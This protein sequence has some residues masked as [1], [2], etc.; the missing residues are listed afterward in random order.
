[1]RNLPLTF[2]I[3]SSLVV[4]CPRSG[5]AQSA[6]AAV[7]IAEISADLGT[8]RKPLRGNEAERALSAAWPI[9]PA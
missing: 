4:V 5:S 1:M 8:C 2:F 9:N 3:L 7:A 6:S